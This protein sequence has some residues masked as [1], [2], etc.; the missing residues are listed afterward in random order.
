MAKFAS[1]LFT[2]KNAKTFDIRHLSET[3]A[4]SFLQ[5]MK[6]V[7][8][9]STH[10]MRYVGMP[11]PSVEE[12]AK[13]LK[14][15]EDDDFSLSLGV[16]DQDKLIG[17]LHFYSEWKG[18]P[19]IRHSARFA[20]MILKDYWNLGIGK[21]LL[22]LQ[23]THAQ[24]INVIRIEALVRSRNE[25][26]I[27]L[28]L[29]HG[30]QIEGARKKASKIDGIF[31]DEFYIAKLLDEEGLEWIPPILTTNRL[32]LRPISLNDAESMFEYA[33]NPNVS[34]YT[35]WE[36]HQS[37][38]NSRDNIKN[39]VF[40]SYRGN[41]PEPLGITLKENPKKLIGTVGCGWVSKK[42]KCMELA[43]ALSEDYWGQGITAEA[44][45]AVMEYCFKEYDVKRIQAHYKSE[46]IQSGR[47]MEKIGM[48]YEGELKSAKFY[49]DRFWDMKIY[50]KVLK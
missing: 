32:I 22:E 42:N 31:Q 41:V 30:F 10:T 36:P 34:K 35:L 49:R 18:H 17:Y 13:R 44:A 9:D 39:D 19:W 20:M 50:A 37:V 48:T 46:N 8:Q 28:Y 23:D 5:F 43:Y 29:H 38:Q 21:K 1:T 27:R 47:V 6:Q 45:Q 14:A 7:E 2:A 40:A 16:F 4:I 3:D 26:G 15:Q 11:Q 24:K 25:Q 12:Q 33:K